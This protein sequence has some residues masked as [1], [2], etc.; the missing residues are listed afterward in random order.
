MPGIS[1]ERMHLFL[2][3]YAEGDRVA[4]GGGVADENEAIEVAEMPL[5]VLA[6]RADEGGL[7]DL[8]TLLLVQTLRLRRPDLFTA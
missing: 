6:R 1:T 3:P 2:A 5:A 8:K 4:A 7:G